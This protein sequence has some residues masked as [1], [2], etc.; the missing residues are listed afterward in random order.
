MIYHARSVARAC[1]HA[2]VIC[3]MPFG[4]HQICGRMPAQ[5][6]P[7]DEGDRRDAHLQLEGGV[8][9]C[10]TVCAG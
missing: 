3:D 10:D 9:I 6:P 8:E 2:L 7:N 4:S 1:Q 5:C